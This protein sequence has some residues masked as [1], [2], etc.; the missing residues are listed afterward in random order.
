VL[1]NLFFLRSRIREFEEC[2][3]VPL[4]FT[5]D[6]IVQNLIN[7]SESWDENDV[8]RVSKL[9]EPKLS[10]E[11]DLPTRFDG[12]TFA[13]ITKSILSGKANVSTEHVHLSHRDWHLVLATASVRYCEKNSVIVKQGIPNDSIY[14][15]KAVKNL[16]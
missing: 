11:E 8:F 10:E 1:N 15:I 7:F 3:K 5:T 9:K 16:L 2:L 6:I 14:R 4:D 12:K 13:K